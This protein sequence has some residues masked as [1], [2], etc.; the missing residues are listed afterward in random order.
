LLLFLEKE[1]YDITRRLVSGGTPPD[2]PGSASP[3]VG[4]GTV[5]FEEGLH[6]LLLLM[7]KEEYNK[8]DWF[9]KKD[10]DGYDNELNAVARNG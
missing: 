2:P 4:Y 10:G 8:N 6:F 5:S 7:E 9:K 3:R 1:E